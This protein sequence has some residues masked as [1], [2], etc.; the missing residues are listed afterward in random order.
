VTSILEI[1]VILMAL[2]IISGLINQYAKIPTTLTILVIAIVN[3]FMGNNIMDIEGVDFDK[4]LL[5]TL[6]LFIAADS[7]KLTFV[8]I[9]ENVRSLLFTACLSV[10]LSIF[11]V[12]V[13]GEYMLPEY[14]I[15]IS[16][17][18]VLAC[19]VLATD[20]ITVTSI[21]SNFKLPHKLK[22][23]AEGESLFNDAFVLIVFFLAIGSLNGDELTISSLSLFTVKMIVGSILIGFVFG[24][25]GLLLISKTKSVQIETM[26]ILLIAYGGFYLAEVF[27]LAGILSVIVGIVTA[28][29]IIDKRIEC[30]KRKPI[31]IGENQNLIGANINFLTEIAGVILFISMGEIM[32]IDN[33]MKY[34][35]ETVI[36]FAATTVIRM[37]MMSKFAWISNKNVKMEDIS[38]HWWKVLTF[39]GVKGGLS[40]LMIHIV[41]DSFEHK[42]LF[43]AI[44]FGNI[45]LSTFIYAGFLTIFIKIN[46]SKFKKECELEHKLID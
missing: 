28:K 36:V 6:P 34:W 5:S 10:L 23:I 4:I 24:F 19:M 18:V 30:D 43:E 35:K 39:A 11:I 41:P 40:I 12:V 22:V 15:S 38:L 17:F 21:F 31:S 44:V 14:T 45:I 8:E 3:K 42:E 32:N 9:K 7:L 26:I 46:E 20:P 16:A 1:C 29:T 37:V 13:I 27:H 25:L 2:Y 33:M